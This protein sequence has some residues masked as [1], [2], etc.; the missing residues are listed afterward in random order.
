MS[1]IGKNIMRARKNLNMYILGVQVHTRV[2][3]I[4][5]KRA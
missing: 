2:H 5:D 3:D 1:D 4:N